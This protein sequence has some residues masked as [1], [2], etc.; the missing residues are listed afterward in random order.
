M[1]EGTERK[2]RDTKKQRRRAKNDG[3][4]KRGEEENGIDRQ[5]RQA[6]EDSERKES[7]GEKNR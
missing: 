5:V 6:D 4:K 3:K 7:D 2:V 1:E